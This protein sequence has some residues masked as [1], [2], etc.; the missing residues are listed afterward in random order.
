VLRESIDSD[1]IPVTASAWVL[2][3]LVGCGAL[4]SVAALVPGR[5]LRWGNLL[6]FGL[7]LPVAELPLFHIALSALTLATLASLGAL[8]TVP[9][10]AALAMV[11]ASVS[12]LAIVQWRALPSER[13]L[14][15]AL[16]DALGPGFTAAIPAERRALIADDGLGVRRLTTPFALRRC[17]VLRHRDIPYGSHR[18]QTLDVYSSANRSPGRA[19]VLIQLHGGGWITGRK[20]DQALPLIY[21]LAARGW[22]VVAANYRLSPASRF[23]DALVDCKRVVAWAREHAL[24][25]DADPQF[26]A[27]TGGSSGAHLASL[28]ALTASRPALQPGFE[29]RATHVSACV[30]LY[31]VYDFVDRDDVRRDG[32]AMTDWLARKV[33]P[34]T[35]ADDPALWELASPIAQCH[36]GA[37]PFLVLHGTHDS[38]AKVEEARRFVARLRS[39]SRAPVA[40]AELPGAQHAFD[41]FHSVRCA[42]SVRAVTQFLEWARTSKLA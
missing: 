13:I 42:A 7:S 31:G 8:S 25:H 20:D 30:P 3:C 35:P 32:G 15:A 36:A 4:M 10:Y 38:L 11:S 21:H 28:V 37:P 9:G 26:L 41:L 2:F 33:M 27:I 29:H 6:W 23:P 22:V 39:I 5:H 40:Y 17:D 14:H 1:R 18:E 19:P 24:E 12:A 16:A 34:S